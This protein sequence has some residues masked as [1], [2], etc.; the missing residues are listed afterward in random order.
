MELKQLHYFLT[1]A[2]Y[3][4]FSR[5]AEVLYISQPALSYQIAEL[6]RELGAPLFIR[7]RR[8]VY[9]SPAG[10]AVLPLAQETL[11]ASKRIVTMAESGFAVEE[12][13]RIL[14]IGFDDTEDH[15]EVTGATRNIAQFQ[16]QNP[17]V[18]LEMEQGSFQSCIEK[19]LNGNLDVAFLVLRHN[20]NLPASLIYHPILATQ[21][22]LLVLDDD[23]VTDYRQALEKYSLLM[24]TQKPRGRSRLLRALEDLGVKPN[25]LSVDSFPT[26]FVYLQS[27]LGCMNFP[28]HYVRAHR[29]QGVKMLQIPS[30]SL[31]LMHVIAWNKKVLNPSIQK[32]VNAFPSP[33]ELE[34]WEK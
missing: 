10:G 33:P 24:I 7:D 5:A 31:K 15:F 3:L 26:A 9:L 12:E 25:V 17:D 8:Q 16:R 1:V 23:S 28:E 22:G 18:H 34:D 13:D 32:L 19:I 29:Y 2:E 11:D 21:V 4:N 30:P 14:R 27:G 20:E 6:E